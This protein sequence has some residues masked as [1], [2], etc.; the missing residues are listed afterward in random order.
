MIAYN[1][2][3]MPLTVFDMKGLSGPRRE[4]IEAAVVARGRQERAV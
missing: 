1:Y 2:A 4:H 3:V